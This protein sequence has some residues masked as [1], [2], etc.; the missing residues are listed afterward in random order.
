MATN[1]VLVQGAITPDGRLVLDEEPGLPA[2]RVEVVVR[3]VPQAEP[4]E[5]ERPMFDT[6][7]RIWAEQEAR[8]F[9][10]GRTLEEAVA[11]VRAMR[12]EWAEHD[13]RLEEFRDRCRARRQAAEGRSGEA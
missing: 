11:E 13:R 7:R 2:G 10:R 6:L 1:E 8:G 5:P 12:D 9:A 3:P 4:A